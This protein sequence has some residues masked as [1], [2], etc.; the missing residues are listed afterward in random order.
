MRIGKRISAG[1][2]TLALGFAVFGEVP[3][4]RTMIGAAMIVAAGL[5]AFWRERR[6]GATPARKGSVR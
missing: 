5:Y 1:L 6:V 2:M 4:A 3:D